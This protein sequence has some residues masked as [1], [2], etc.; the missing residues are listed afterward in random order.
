M[1][2]ISIVRT[3]VIFRPRVED[4]IFWN[5]GVYD[6]TRQCL[7]RTRGFSEFLGGL[8]QWEMRWK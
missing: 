1:L 8:R 7:L 3:N 4:L 6:H 2:G 5:P